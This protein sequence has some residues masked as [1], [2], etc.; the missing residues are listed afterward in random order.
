M[1]R[2]TKLFFTI[3]IISLLAIPMAGCS[4]PLTLSIY[5]PRDGAIVNE[6]A[7]FYAGPAIRGKRGESV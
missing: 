6:S 7:E 2:L 4:K 1:K 5:E 3:I